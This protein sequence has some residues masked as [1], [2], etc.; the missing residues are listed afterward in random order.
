MVLIMLNSFLSNIRTSLNEV[1]S[2]Q[3]QALRQISIRKLLG[4]V[5]MTALLY[6][7]LH[8]VIGNVLGVSVLQW[9]PLTHN[10]LGKGLYM[11]DLI[12]D[13]TSMAIM[14][15]T[16]NQIANDVSFKQIVNQGVKFASN[17]Y[18][19]IKSK[20]LEFQEATLDPSLQDNPEEP[21]SFMSEVSWIFFAYIRKIKRITK[22]ILPEAIY[23]S[24]S[25]SLNANKHIRR[26]RKKLYRAYMN[27]DEQ[28]V[29]EILNQVTP[30]ELYLI[31]RFPLKHNFSIIEEITFSKR[32]EPEL[33]QRLLSLIE[34]GRHFDLLNS[35]RYLNSPYVHLVVTLSDCEKQFET[36][37]NCLPENRHFDFISSVDYLGNTPLMS[38]AESCENAERV[39][40][41]MKYCPKDKV[42]S[43]INK[44]NYEG[45]TTL[46]MFCK[47]GSPDA[48]RYLIN[49]IPKEEL[50]DFFAFNCQGVKAFIIAK[51]Q[52]DEDKMEL[53]KEAGI[54]LPPEY[55]NLTLDELNKFMDEWPSAEGFKVKYRNTPR[56]VLG[57]SANSNL[58]EIKSAYRKMMLF[59]HPDR[60]QNNSDSVEES[61]K[62]IAAYKFFEKPEERNQYLMRK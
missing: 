58:E 21:H 36:M 4:I 8:W 30:D 28:K 51:S 27:N 46:E 25:N 45:K 39:E 37:M 10:Y 32:F 14:A 62:I 35:I 3:I 55:E 17:T 61:K 41:L 22:M 5:V 20:M 53:L 6:T 1:L 48:M 49:L 12:M 9:L 7:S 13:I 52:E 19:S 42:V 50:N 23:N 15:Y 18:A 43:Y 44:V 16:A 59:S 26:T 54:Q 11:F 29:D 2:A 57:V 33:L 40:E 24:I 47:Y 31:L 34:K 38:Q 56:E 60:N